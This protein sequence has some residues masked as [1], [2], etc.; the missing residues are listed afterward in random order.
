MF[1]HHRVVALAGILMSWD[2]EMPQGGITF[3]GPHCSLTVSN[4]WRL[5][6]ISVQVKCTSSWY[7]RSFSIRRNI[8]F[9]K[10]AICH[11]NLSTPLWEPPLGHVDFQFMRILLR[12]LARSFLTTWMNPI[13]QVVEDE[14]Q[15]FAYNENVCSEQDYSAYR[16]TSKT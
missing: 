16:Y 15:R 4:R 7:Q 13:A 2:A 9:K 1:N 3:K 11:I 10:L 8:C 6:D 12:E 14:F 5:N